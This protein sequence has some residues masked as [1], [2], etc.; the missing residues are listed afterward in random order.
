[1]RPLRAVEEV[2]ILVPLRFL[3]TGVGI[4]VGDLGR[5]AVLAREVGVEV[6]EEGGGGGGEE[7]VA[8]W[9]VCVCK[10]WEVELGVKSLE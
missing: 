2:F 9:T 10:F 4:G 5:F 3:G 7:D 6:C 8:V 1:M